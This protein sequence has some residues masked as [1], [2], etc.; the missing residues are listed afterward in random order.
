[1]LPEKESKISERFLFTNCRFGKEAIEIWQKESKLRCAKREKTKAY[2]EY[3]NWKESE[4]EVALFT[5]YSYADFNVP[6][7]FS[8]IFDYKNPEKYCESKMKLTHSIWE[9]WYPVNYVEHGYKHLLIFNF[10]EGIPKIINE[11]YIETEK[12]S[13]VTNDSFTL[14]ICQ[15]EDYEKI[16]EDIIKDKESRK[17]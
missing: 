15:I 13:R 8:C 16:K 9:G 10:E 5:M 12:F 1:M 2:F 7:E 14:G 11:L 6:K 4:N 17:E 3:L